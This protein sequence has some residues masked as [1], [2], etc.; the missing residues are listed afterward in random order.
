MVVKV[1]LCSLNPSIVSF[2]N[3][4]TNL[5]T[6]IASGNDIKPCVSALNQKSTEILHDVAFLSENFL[7]EYISSKEEAVILLCENPTTEFKSIEVNLFN[8]FLLNDINLH[9]SCF[10]IERIPYILNFLMKAASK[11]DAIESKRVS[12]NLI[13]KLDE[14]G[15]EKLNSLIANIIN[16]RPIEVEALENRITS[17]E[18]DPEAIY[19]ILME[20]K[21]TDHVISVDAHINLVNS[22]HRFDFQLHPE[23]LSPSL[24]VLKGLLLMKRTQIDFQSAVIYFILSEKVLVS[25]PDD[26][27]IDSFAILLALALREKEISAARIEAMSLEMIRHFR[28]YS[29]LVKDITKIFSCLRIIQSLDNDSTEASFRMAISAITN[30]RSMESTDP[31]LHQIIKIDYDILKSAITRFFRIYTN[32]SNPLFINSWKTVCM[33]GLLCYNLSEGNLRKNSSVNIATSIGY[34]LLFHNKASK[35]YL[36]ELINDI[37][38]IIDEVIESTFINVKD[39]NIP[40]NFTRLAGTIQLIQLHPSQDSINSY[41]DRICCQYILNVPSQY[42]RYE[43]IHSFRITDKR[44]VYIPA[45]LSFLDDYLKGN[46]THSTYLKEFYKFL[47]DSKLVSK[48][49]SIIVERILSN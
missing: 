23:W 30:L 20:L 8:Q 25:L 14:E 5:R 4:V 35:N 7:K 42:N 48:T 27:V 34:L 38:P 17:S 41:T 44:N 26:R 15:L 2:N 22:M 9:E 6:T 32:E 43:S 39:V 46:S 11:C 36:T 12:S 24:E 33:L 18:H 28:P 45:F 3:L 19:S 21:R 13:D 1:V 16:E 29:N 49:E 47:K 31:I 37:L 10:S 40:M